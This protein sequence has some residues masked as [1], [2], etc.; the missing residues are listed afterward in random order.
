MPRM[1]RPPA[2][3]LDSSG[4]DP[5][6]ELEARRAAA[7]P[8]G[9]HPR[10]PG[11]RRRPGPPFTQGVHGGMHMLM[12]AL[13]WLLAAAAIV[14]GSLAFLIAITPPV[15]AAAAP[16]QAASASV[17]ADAAGEAAQQ[18][19]LRGVSLLQWFLAFVAL[20]N[21]LLSVSTWHAARQKAANAR[22]DALED[23]MRER[24]GLLDLGHVRLQEALEKAPSHDHLAEVYRELRGVATKV[25]TMVGA[26]AQV[27]SLL[28]QLVAQ[29]LHRPH[30]VGP[31]RHP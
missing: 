25:D 18:D 20:A 6:A 14:L 9:L 30:S 22:L 17:Q 7:L 5:F 1:N 23:E 19:L 10:G 24:L 26:Q 11:V 27:T 8:I 3:P 4:P 29:Q 12:R 2:D 31:G 13:G 28:Q 16:A 21:M 15:R